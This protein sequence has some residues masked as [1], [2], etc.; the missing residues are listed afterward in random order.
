MHKACP[1]TT[2]LKLIPEAL[3]IRYTVRSQQG[4]ARFKHPSNSRRH[5]D[6]AHWHES[7]AS[8]V[9]DDLHKDAAGSVLNVRSKIESEG[10]KSVSSQTSKYPWMQE[11]QPAVIGF[12][13]SGRSLS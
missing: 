4:D 1:P 10:G 11:S 2:P 12:T 3:L 5:S 6:F 7:L 8:I 9:G 13:N